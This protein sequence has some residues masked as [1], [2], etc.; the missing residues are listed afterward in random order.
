[1][2]MPTIIFLSSC[3]CVIALSFLSLINNLGDLGALDSALA[4]GM[5]SRVVEGGANRKGVAA[6][7]L[8]IQYT[9]LYSMPVGSLSSVRFLLS[10][11]SCP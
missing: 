1:M 5:K 10:C 11:L 9:M 2:A 3:S 7:L 8:P 6:R 4:R